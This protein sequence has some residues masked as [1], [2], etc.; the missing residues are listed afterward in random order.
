[1]FL[2]KEGKMKKWFTLGIV[3]AFAFLIVAFLVGFRAKEETL[4]DE[5][6]TLTGAEVIKP[7]DLDKGDKL[8]I[9]IRLKEGMP[10]AFA[11]ASDVNG[12]GDVL[13]L[14]NRQRIEME[15]E[16]PKTTLYWLTFNGEPGTVIEVK[17]TWVRR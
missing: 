4:I 16:V 6:I 11:I 7:F 10:F 17:V 14:P 2:T 12:G 15:W 3:V 13:S 9:Y 1:M 5:T 8:K